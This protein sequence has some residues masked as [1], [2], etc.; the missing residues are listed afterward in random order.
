[1]RGHRAGSGLPAVFG[2]LS[3]PR[4]AHVAQPVDADPDR[5]PGVAVQDGAAQRG[6]AGAADPDRRMRALHR[7]RSR[8]DI[9]E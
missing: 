1:M 6:V 2:D 7:V 9:P 5:M 4:Q 3:E 8:A